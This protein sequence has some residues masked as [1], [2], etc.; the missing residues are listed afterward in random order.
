M[1][2]TPNL[3]EIRD[4]SV[5]FA[6]VEGPDL[7]V[8][9]Q[10]SLELKAGG[11]MGLVGESG[12]GKSTLCR[13]ILKTLRAPAYIAG[14]HVSWQGESLLDRPPPVLNQLRWRDI[15]M[16]VQSALDSLNPV[17]NIE[18][19]LLDTMRAHGYRN[20]EANR[21][22]LAELIA[23][24]GL[25][26]RH[27]KAYPHELSGGM[28]QRVV[29]AMALALNPKL[30]IMDE[31][32]T[33]LD[34]VTQAE[35]L[36]HILDLQEKLGFAILL[37][38]HDL[39]LALEFCHEIS[40]MYAGRI[41]ERGKVGPLQQNPQHPYTA[42]LLHSFPQPGSKA[43]VMRGVPGD[44]ASFSSLPSG[45]AFHPRCTQAVGVCP[46]LVPKL[47][48]KG[49]TTVACHNPLQASRAEIGP[50]SESPK[51][52]PNKKLQSLSSDL[53]AVQN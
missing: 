44:P 27:L 37:V 10:V 53:R 4:L 36:G 35:I 38:T 48:Q 42:G 17:V 20:A 9:D 33:A 28:R 32:T 8:L 51:F 16:V 41:V 30:L 13:A 1:L 2:S 50:T 34:V 47:E 12:C 19:Q 45:C 43:Q 15:S 7:L 24:V 14:G 18:A 49:S 31:P 46:E 23:L 52:M 26:Q 6:A 3:L 22:R 40:V 11:I 39:P 21:E 25:E 5:A 29:I